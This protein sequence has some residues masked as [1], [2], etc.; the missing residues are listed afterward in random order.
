MHILFLLELYYPNIGGVETLFRNL[1]DQLAKEGHEITIITTRFDSSLPAEEHSDNVHIY[2][3]AYR[4]RYLFTLFSIIPT[5]IKAKNCGLI[6]TTSYNAALPAFLA[7]WLRRKK[8]II[9]FH[10]VWGSL[11]FRLPFMSWGSKLLHY[12]YEQLILRFPFHRFVAVSEFT[13]SKLLAAG[14]KPE[15]VKVIYNG[16]NYQEFEKIPDEVLPNTFTCTYFGRLGMSKGLDLLIPAFARFKQTYSE[17]RLK[18]ILPSRPASFLAKI[19][20][21]VESHQLSGSVAW[22]HNLDFQDLLKELKSSHCVVI[23]SYSEGFCF[24]A[25]ETCALGVPVVSSGRGALSEVVS[26]KWIQMHAFSVD[27]LSK[28][29]G[30]AKNGNWETGPL[31]KF[32]LEETVTGYMK[33]YTNG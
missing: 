13:A 33:L 8:V 24:A 26:G 16:L 18:L 15:R 10:E 7:G 23:P 31:K 30:K 6:H 2:R 21:M 4:N 1:V 12:L 22:K 32:P 5:I 27:D 25:A 17:A 11:W 29:L 28:A 19:K 3:Y 14:V 9:T 20:K